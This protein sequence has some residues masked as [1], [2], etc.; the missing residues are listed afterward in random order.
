MNPAI[1]KR[2]ARALIALSTE[3]EFELDSLANCYEH[4]AL[5]KLLEN[6]AFSN[7]ERL[8]LVHKLELS[9]ILTRCLE[10]LIE[11]NRTEIIPELRTAYGRELDMKLGRLRAEITSAHALTPNQLDEITQ[12][13]IGRLGRPVVPESKVDP[14]VLGG[15]RAQIGGL[16]FDSTLETQLSQLRRVLCN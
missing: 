11:S 3:L 5:K 10:M 8:Q 14:S 2:Y 13:L 16:V 7:T 9:P 4:T 1:A 15:V 6:P 12:S